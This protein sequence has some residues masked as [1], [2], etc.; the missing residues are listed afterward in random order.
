MI[1]GVIK[2]MVM[3]SPYK[4]VTPTVFFLGSWDHAT[5][6]IKINP[7]MSASESL[8]KIESVYKKYSPGTPFDYRFADEEYSNKFSAEVRIGKMVGFFVALAILISCSGLFGLALFI[9]EQRTKEIAIRK[10]MGA[11]ALNLWILLSKDFIALIITSFI[12]ATPLAAY[13]MYNWLQNYQYR[14]TISWLIFAAAGIGA[15]IIT[16]FTISFYTLKAITTN[17]ARSLGN[18]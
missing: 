13:I 5:V 1:I 18:E 2:D 9:T 8:A 4:P 15:I 16:L 3:E 7:V 10:V 11:S 12:I 14:T 17:P 6:N